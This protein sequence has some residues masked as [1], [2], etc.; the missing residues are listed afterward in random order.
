VSVE[1]WRAGRVAAAALTQDVESH[2]TN[3]QYALDS[4][5]AARVR[6][7]YFLTSNIAVRYE[8]LSRDLANAGEIG[9]HTENHRLLGGTAAEEQRRRLKTTQRALTRM[10]GLPVDGLR[11]PQEQFDETTMAAW[12]ATGGRYLLGANDSRTASPELLPIGTD[13][14]VLIGRTAS[15]DIA[16]AAAGHNEPTAVARYFLAEYER[17]RGLGGLYVL[18]YHSQLLARPDLVPA[19]AHLARTIAADTAVWFTT[20]GEI[21]EWWRERAQLAAT[22]RMREDGFDVVVRNRGERLVRGAV[23]RVELP[24]PA[25]RPIA[26]ASTALLPAPAG[27]VRLLIPPVPGKATRTYVV[28]YAGAQRAGE[29]SLRT[30]TKPRP[31]RRVRPRFWWFPWWR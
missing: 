29:A 28:G 1:P 9:T 24:A 23:M 13:T 3:A 27:T 26:R 14:L 31:A 16:A 25:P 30:L 4:L 7:T 11:P 6:S 18:S 12:V 20:T 21:A 19:L 10:F 15:D 22:V 8:R 5:R 17:L 2:F